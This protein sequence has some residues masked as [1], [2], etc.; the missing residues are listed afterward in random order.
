MHAYARLRCWA[1]DDCWGSYITPTCQ[2]LKLFITGVKSLGGCHG[3]IF[4]EGI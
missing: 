2:A 4:G 1:V 3:I